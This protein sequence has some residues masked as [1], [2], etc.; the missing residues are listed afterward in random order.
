MSVRAGQERLAMALYHRIT[1][2]HPIYDYL[3]ADTFVLPDTTLS[4]SG[5][6][7]PGVG[8]W[9]LAPEPIVL[10]VCFEHR[11][12]PLRVRLGFVQPL[13]E[14]VDLLVRDT[15]HGQDFELLRGESA[16]DMVLQMNVR[17][18]DEP[19]V[20]EAGDVLARCSVR[21]DPLP[22]TPP[23]SPVPPFVEDRPGR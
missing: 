17:V 14:R 15:V 10:P 12:T 18:R 20:V 7:D 23:C 2:A 11:S 16:H 22:P 13:D 9:L 1:S 5:D 3:D 8:F 4:P 6:D 19:I 21:L